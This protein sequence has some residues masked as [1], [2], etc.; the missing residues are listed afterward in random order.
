MKKCY[1][2][3]MALFVLVVLGCS[4]K[5]V[6]RVEDAGF[7][8]LTKYYIAGEIQ[9][10]DHI[11]VPFFLYPENSSEMTILA[12]GMHFK[13]PYTIKKG[14]FH[15]ESMVPTLGTVQMDALITNNSIKNATFSAS[16]VAEPYKILDATILEKSTNM[17]LLAG[18]TFVG[19]GLPG[20]GGVTIVFEK[21][22]AGMVYKTK[23]AK[24]ENF[25]SA[26]SCR[27][28]GNAGVSANS[29]LLTYGVVLDDSFLAYVNYGGKAYTLTM[30]EVKK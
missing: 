6:D 8:D 30:K 2:L 11:A 3:M 20:A 14:V 15:T 7:S 21:T 26:T 19:T 13:V 22:S 1:F 27:L 18:R 4:K 24:Q 28:H 16:S 23:T 25:T 9:N 5:Q 12:Y 29:G 17:N 10:G